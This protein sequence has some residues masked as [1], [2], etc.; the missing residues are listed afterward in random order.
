MSMAEAEKRNKTLKNSSST[1]DL[2]ASVVGGSGGIL[3]DATKHVA[4]SVGRWLMNN[5][6]PQQLQQEQQNQQEQAP[7]I[8]PETQKSNSV[9][10]FLFHGSRR[11]S[12]PIK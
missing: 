2:M 12:T 6:Q 4:S 11:F 5:K 10:Q 1:K 8:S 7:A 9:K 3:G